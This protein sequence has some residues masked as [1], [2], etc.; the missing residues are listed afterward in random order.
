[1]GSLWSAI[2]CE[3]KPETDQQGHNN[4]PVPAKEKFRFIA[5]F[6]TKE[7]KAEYIQWL[8]QNDAIELLCIP[9]TTVPFSQKY[10]ITLFCPFNKIDSLKSC[11]WFVDLWDPGRATACTT[12]QTH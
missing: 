6:E 7:V 10:K 1:M 9:A 2:G 3:S 8:Q 4:G 12:A 11:S 5:R